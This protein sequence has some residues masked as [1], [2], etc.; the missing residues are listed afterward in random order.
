MDVLSICVY[1]LN[2]AIRP[3]GDRV[4]GHPTQM[5]RVWVIVFNHGQARWVTRLAMG[6]AWV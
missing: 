5:G 6:G 1:K 4:H 3:I 2:P